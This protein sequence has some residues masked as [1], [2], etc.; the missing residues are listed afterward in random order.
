LFS[1]G[2]AFFFARIEMSRIWIAQ[3]ACCQDTKIA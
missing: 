2:L 1:V 3:G